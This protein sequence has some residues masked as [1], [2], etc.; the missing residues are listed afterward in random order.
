MERM[1]GS[2]LAPREMGLE[3]MKKADPT[4][5]SPWPAS[6]KFGG[7]LWANSAHGVNSAGRAGSQVLCR[8]LFGLGSYHGMEEVIGSIPI[9]STN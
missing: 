7:I 8:L 3:A 2:F 4:Q 6:Q 5:I 9:R 1:I